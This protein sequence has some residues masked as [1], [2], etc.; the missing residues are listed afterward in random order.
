MLKRT[1]IILLSFLLLTNS[2]GFVVGFSFVQKKIKKDIKTAIKNNLKDDE[3]VFLK[4]H[5]DD[6]AFKRIDDKEFLYCNTMYDIIEKRIEGNVMIIRCVSDE[7]E[8]RLFK[9]LD[10]LIA[11]NISSEGTAGSS[12]KKLFGLIQLFVD[13][14]SDTS[15]ELVEKSISYFS[16]YKSSPLSGVEISAFKPPEL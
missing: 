13:K 1:I 10:D 6:K 3:V 9:N 8:T 16:Y 7:M 12:L 5:T 11:K 14:T 4:I 2:I 15:N